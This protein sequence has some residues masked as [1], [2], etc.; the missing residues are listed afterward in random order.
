MTF[1]SPFRNPDGTTVI[2]PE[3]GIVRG[4]EGIRAVVP[5]GA[6]PDGTFIKLGIVPEPSGDEALPAGFCHVGGI[7][8]EM[9]DEAGESVTA[10]EELKL[11]VPLPPGD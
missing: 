2:G 9:R 10:G 7:D 1:A 6:V 3:G 5:S 8:L 11:S 4:P